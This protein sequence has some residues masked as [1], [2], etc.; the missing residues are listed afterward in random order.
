MKATTINEFLG[1]LGSGGSKGIGSPF[2]GDNSQPGPTADPSLS[3]QINP[4]K[5]SVNT[6]A[7][8]PKAGDKSLSTEQ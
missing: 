6:G 3:T 4:G 2:T 8:A 7:I 5:P 1:G